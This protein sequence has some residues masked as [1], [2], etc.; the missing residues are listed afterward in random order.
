MTGRAEVDRLKK[1]LDA[2]FERCGKLGSGADLE[3]H[4]DFAR[5]LCVLVSGYLE[6][7]VAELVLEHAR[8]SGGPTLQKYVEANTKRFA[9]AN[10]E[11]LKSFLGSFHSDWRARLDLVLVDEFKDAVDS[12]VSLRHTI[13]HGGSAGV[14]YRRI[15]D[16]YILVQQ[17]VGEIA[18]L[19]AP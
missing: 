16:Y 13:A 18:D 14:T 2:T 10:C 9:N 8:R 17:V 12:I 4:S 3:V 19:C 7:A 6:R 11:R 15:R 1:R 5:Y